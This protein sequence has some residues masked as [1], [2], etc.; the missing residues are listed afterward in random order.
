MNADGEQETPLAAP[1]RIASRISAFIRVYL[2]F[3]PV[4]PSCSGVP[5]PSRRG[6]AGQ[7]RAEQAEAALVRRRA[8]RAAG[9]VGYNLAVVGCRLSLGA[10]ACGRADQRDIGPH[11]NPLPEGDGTGRELSVGSFHTSSF[12]LEGDSPIFV[13]RKSGQSPAFIPNPQSPIPNPQSP[14]P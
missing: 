4:R 3:L 13:G 7:R 9:P 14:N 10:A 2:R 12:R 6:R 5:A 1:S 11:P 8:F